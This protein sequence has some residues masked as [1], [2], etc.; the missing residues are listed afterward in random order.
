MFRVIQAELVMKIPR[1]QKGLAALV[2]VFMLALV[3]I[4]YAVN[5]L[6]SSDIQNEKNKK[7]AAALAEAKAAL[8]GWSVSHQVQPGILPFPDRG[9]DGNYDGNSDCVVGTP[10]FNLL[11]GRLPFL[12]QTAPCAAPVNGLATS[13]TDGSG[14][15]LWYAVSRNLIRTSIVPI[16]N[17]SIIDAPPE[18]WLIVRDKNGQPISSRVAAVIIAPG[19]PIGTQNRAGI[20][21]VENYLDTLGAFSNSNYDSAT[22]D[23]FM[24]KEDGSFNDQLV[25]ITIDELM[26]AVE[27][28]VAKEVILGLNNYYAESAPLPNDRFYPYAADISFNCI[29]G[30]LAGALP[31]GAACASQPLTGLPAWFSQNGWEGYFY[32]AISPDCSNNGPNRGCASGVITVG[33]QTNINAIIISTGRE[34]AQ[35]ELGLSPQSRPSNSVEDYLD[36]IENTNEDNVYDAVSKRKTHV[37]NDQVFIVAP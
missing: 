37:Y 32:Y 28:R 26:D 17:P 2:L 5:A 35:T 3:A 27:K 20:A 6:E 9:A 31:I 36:S 8:I 16:I 12:G 4:G 21:S 18:N 30:L 33:E 11:I 23:F 19:N 34:L 10:G 25:F 13:L 15:Q 22:E 7:T 14:E 24:I 29:D 1:R